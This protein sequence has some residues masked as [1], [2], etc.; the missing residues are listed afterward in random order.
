MLTVNNGPDPPSQPENV[1]RGGYQSCT[2]IF[3]ASIIVRD[4]PRSGHIWD[5]R[6]EPSVTTQRQGCLAAVPP[7]LISPPGP[8]SV[9]ITP[10]GGGSS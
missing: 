2:R 10:V 3:C 5:S 9:G 4:G 8:I 1:P 7:G 6:A